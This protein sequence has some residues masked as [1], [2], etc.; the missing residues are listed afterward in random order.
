M[1]GLFTV[2]FFNIALPANAT[3]I[4][5]LDLPALTRESAVI[6]VGK[7]IAVRDIGRVTHL[8][9]AHSLS[10]RKFVV[11]LQPSRFLK[12]SDTTNIVTFHFVQPDVSTGYDTVSA[13]QFGMFFLKRGSENELIVTNP[14]YP[15]IVASLEAAS[16]SGED[17]N[18]VISEVISVL[19]SPRTS[20]ENKVKAVMVLDRV[21]IPSVTEALRQA[22]DSP[23]QELRICAV[24]SLLKRNDISRLDT[25]EKILIETPVNTDQYLLAT[26]AVAVEGIRNPQ[27]IPSLARLLNAKHPQ[28]RQSA[29]SALRNTGDEA[30]IAPLIKSLYDGERKVRYQSVMGL[31]EIT[32]QY[33]WGVAVD[34][35]NN[36]EQRYLT[37]WRNWAKQR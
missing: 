17:L 35:Y 31:A 18:R 36:D 3:I 9:Q 13:N 23:E 24:A 32:G 21:R 27:A 19:T 10:A 4:P 20:T 7:V 11:E 14:Y 12:G 28:V 30:A 29:T 16:S 15:S 26:L 8:W 2:L 37:Y 1:T 6:V 34:L 5:G 33:S 22:A 25:A